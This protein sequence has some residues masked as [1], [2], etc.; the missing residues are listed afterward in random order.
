M[1]VFDYITKFSSDGDS[2]AVVE[3]LNKDTADI[4]KDPRI[5]RMRR[6]LKVGTKAFKLKLYDEAIKYYEEAGKIC[7]EMK[8]VVD[9]AA[10]PA[11]FAERFFSTITPIFTTL[12]I[13]DV[14]ID[15]SLV[16]YEDDMSTL[17]TSEVKKNIQQRLNLFK[18]TIGRNVKV[19]SS[20]KKRFAS[21]PGVK[22]KV[23]ANRGKL[24]KYK[25]KL[26]IK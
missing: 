13:Y 10:E 5:K 20:N 9:S 22:A 12:P 18:I 6:C 15:S 19:A 23:E 11:T 21:D 3:G 1:K 4:L 14:K 17:T 7:D 25:T 24:E 16:L 2:A 8:K 26:G